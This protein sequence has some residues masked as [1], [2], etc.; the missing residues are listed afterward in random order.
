MFPL[1]S[2]AEHDHAIG[3]PGARAHG[4]AIVGALVVFLFAADAF[5][6]EPVTNTADT[7]KKVAPDPLA[8][9]PDPA[10]V[11]KPPMKSDSV[12]D[13]IPETTEQ[14]LAG[15]LFMFPILQDTAFMT[16]HITFAQ[17]LELLQVP[18][19]PVRAGRTYDV[20]ALGVDES[21]QFGARFLDRFEAS[22]GGA[23]EAYSGSGVK[24]ALV[25]GAAYWFDGPLGV[26]MRIWR[27]RR[28]EFSTRI[29]GA[30]GSSKRVEFIPVLQQIAAQ[31][32]ATTVDAVV[33][34]DTGR[35]I[36][37]PASR[38][39]VKVSFNL[40]HA[41]GRTLGFQGAFALSESFIHLNVAYDD[42]RRISGNVTTPELDGALTFDMRPLLEQLPLALIA[43]YSIAWSYVATQEPG[44][45]KWL[46][47]R[48]VI[49]GGAYY[50]GRKDLQVGLNVR[51]IL[52]FETTQGF[53]T[54]GRPF[55]LGK[56]NFTAVQLTLRYIW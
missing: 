30:F 25:G 40:A 46:E 43:E 44:L 33:D 29:G 12:Y 11:L 1:S 14:V 38:D 32:A 10:L 34:G 5:A 50:S 19:A 3:P 21:I 24:S 47:A 41:F 45:S 26:G 13:P 17:A 55:P 49:S 9:S 15:H 6:E 28:T 52:T 42:Q 16:T 20:S 8:D 36:T 54:Q 35:K 27:G 2:R 22:L 31:P 7:T 23:A 48:Q 56:P 4:T 39:A 51:H 37:T 53:D 18:D